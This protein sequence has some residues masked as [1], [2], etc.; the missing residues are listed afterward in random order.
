MMKLKINQSFTKKNQDKKLEI[1][2]IKIEVEIPTTKKIK[3]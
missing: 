2:R 3:L 1:K